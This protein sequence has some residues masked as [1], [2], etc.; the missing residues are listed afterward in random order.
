MACGFGV[1][2]IHFRDVG[3][4]WGKPCVAEKRNVFDLEKKGLKDAHAGEVRFKGNYRCIET[5]QGD[6][7]PRQSEH[8][9]FR[10]WGGCFGRLKRSPTGKAP[11][12]QAL[13]PS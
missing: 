13:V 6:E 5:A 3:A 7:A 10:E 9:I 4:V 2:D 8:Y 11:T 12:G 1:A